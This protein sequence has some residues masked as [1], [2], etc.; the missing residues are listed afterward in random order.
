[1]N[2][3][4]PD[5][6][7]AAAYR[8]LSEPSTPARQLST[9][10]DAASIA[11]ELLRTLARVAPYD[12]GAV[13]VA[14]PGAGLHELAVLSPGGGGSG[15]APAG[16]WDVGLASQTAIAD[17]WRTEQVQVRDRQHQ[18]QG[19]RQG[20]RRG[21]ALVLPLRVGPR[22]VGLVAVETGRSRAYPPVVVTA[23]EAA[24]H[25]LALR[26]DTALIVDEVRTLA[27]TEER[28]RLGREIHDGVAQDLASLGYALDE[29]VADV[30]GGDSAL[31]AGL[32]RIREELSGV[33]REVRQSISDL[34][35]SIDEHGGLG[36]AVAEYA[37]GVGTTA[38]FRVHLRL[39]GT[40]ARLPAGAEA[41]LLRIAQEAITN[42]RKHARASNLWVTCLVTPPSALLR[43]EDDGAGLPPGAR[44]GSYGLEIMKERAQ[45][46]SASLSVREREPNGTLVEVT[47]GHPAGEPVTGRSSGDRRREKH[48]HEGADQRPAG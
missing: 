48:A 42:V 25:D 17:A 2:T 8:R 40:T 1:M 39:D 27:T 23:A 15:K 32:C 10:P 41:E 31:L 6:P 4:G 36:G 44:P 22:T 11:A 43:I 37:R 24:A 13:L 7:Y 33:L 20:P 14:G 29:L 18:M 35:T 19:Q 47:L 16:Q 46:L 28:R 12:G 45:R 34:R 5:E 9:D 26:L 3:P 38:P 30:E 21:S